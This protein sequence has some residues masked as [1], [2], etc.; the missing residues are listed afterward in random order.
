MYDDVKAIYKYIRMWV[1]RY[2]GGSDS[3]F[4]SS[5]CETKGGGEGMGAIGFPFRYMY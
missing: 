3:K 4:F 1:C 5:F 2:T